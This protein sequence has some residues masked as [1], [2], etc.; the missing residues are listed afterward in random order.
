MASANSNQVEPV[1]YV[2]DQLVQLTR[3]SPPAATTLLPDA[4]LS[5]RFEEARRYLL[6]QLDDQA[7]LRRE[8]NSP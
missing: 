6:K 2:R 8:T 4:W 1:A 3:N 5:A 7:L